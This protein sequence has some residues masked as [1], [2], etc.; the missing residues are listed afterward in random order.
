MIYRFEVRG[1]DPLPKERPRA[2]DGVFYTP[3][4]TKTYEK[5]LAEIIGYQANQA[6]VD[7]YTF[8]GRK[9]GII[10]RY[11]RKTKH[12]VDTDNLTKAV[13]DALEHVL[14]ENDR[15]VA[16]DC[17]Y[18]DYDAKNPGVTLLVMSHEKWLALT[19]VERWIQ[20]TAKREVSTLP[21]QK[22]NTIKSLDPIWIIK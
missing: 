12:F 15:Y 17:A 3:Q 16:G 7:Q 8:E 19:N 14:W 18:I 1:I 9:I 6:G 13:K 2:K 10:V 4:K 11:T 20:A 22:G 21:T 5:I